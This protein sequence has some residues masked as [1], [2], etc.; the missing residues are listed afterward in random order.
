MDSETKLL[1]K[2]N[3][4]RIHNLEVALQY[5]RDTA[6]VITILAEH[7]IEAIKTSQAPAIPEKCRPFHLQAASAICE[8]IQSLADP[9][10]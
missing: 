8:K 2:N 1:L 6:S 3:K 7:V 4:E 9:D 10:R 5:H